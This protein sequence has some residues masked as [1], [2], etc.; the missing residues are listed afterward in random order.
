MI[1]EKNKLFVGNLDSRVKWFHLKEFFGQYG[2]V[3]YTKVAFDRESNRSRGFWFVVFANDA[4]AANALEK[5]QGVTITVAE[6]SFPDKP[7]RLMYAETSEERAQQYAQKLSDNEG[8]DHTATR[9]EEVSTT[10]I[11]E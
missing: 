4:D 1:I 7:L 3:T 10:D 2:E 8:W 6:A 5:A 9:S 11:T